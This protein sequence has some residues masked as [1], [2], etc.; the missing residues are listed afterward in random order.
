MLDHPLS[1]SLNAGIYAPT[2]L[3]TDAFADAAETDDSGKDYV[4][5]RIQQRNGK[6]SL[7]TIQVCS[8]F[9]HGCLCV[10]FRDASSGCAPPAACALVG[11]G[12]YIVTAVNQGLHPVVQQLSY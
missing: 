8:T 2:V 10:Y 3:P 7:T 9:L 12:Q 1:T 5:I 6:K 11:L 4:H